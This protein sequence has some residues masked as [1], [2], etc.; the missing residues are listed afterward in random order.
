MLRVLAVSS[1][2]LVLLAGCGAE[3]P[4]PEAALPATPLTSSTGTPSPSPETSPETDAETSP[5]TRPET[6]ASP[7]PLGRRQ[8]PTSG[9]AL[10]LDPAE[11]PLLADGN[12]WVTTATTPE[13]TDPV[14][15]CQ[16]ASLTDIGA[17]STLRRTFANGHG[18]ARHPA[19]AVQVVADFADAR[20]A[21]RALKVL[22]SWW[23]D[24]AEQLD[25]PHHRVA[26]LRTVEVPAG[27]ARA[28]RA[29][30]GPRAR[31][32]RHLEGLAFLRRGATITVVR[33]EARAGGFAG[34]GANP[35]RGA[36]R[37]LADRV[38]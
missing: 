38:G 6:T 3:G 7:A 13:D 21:T 28:Y 18:E 20:S 26:A 16:R 1:L 36:V 33:V 10:L 8:V 15:V 29:T 30:Y 2:A 11:L 22:E 19:R 25:Q 5:E 34:P 9:R 23:R 12:R 31:A 32:A 14:G 37:R 4:S 24:C 17:V 27:T 35:A